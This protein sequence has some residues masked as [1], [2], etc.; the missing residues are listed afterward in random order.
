[1]GI[2]TNMIIVRFTLSII[3]FLPYFSKAQSCD[4][5]FVPPATV[6]GIEVT[7]RDSGSVSIFPAIGGACNLYTVPPGSIYLGR[8]GQ[9]SYEIIFDKAISVLSFVITGTGSAQNETFIFTTNSGN[10]TLIDKGSCKSSINNNVLFSGGGPPF[11]RPGGGE[12]DIINGTPFTRVKI[13]GPGIQNGSIISFCSEVNSVQDTLIKI[14][15]GDSAIIN[16]IYRKKS[17]VY[18]DTIIN[19]SANGSDSIVVYQLR[20]DSIELDLGEDTS[21]CTGESFLLSAGIKNTNASFIWQNS[22]TDSTILINSSGLYWVEI[23]LNGCRNSDSIKVGFN[24][25]P[26]IELGENDTLCKNDTLILNPAT[27]NANYLWQ[28]NSTDSIFIVKETGLYWCEVELNNCKTRDSINIYFEPPSSSFLVDTIL[29]CDGREYLFSISTQYVSYKWQNG[30]AESSFVASDEGLY[31]CEVQSSN[32]IY[33]DSTYLKVI[34]CEVKIDFPN[35]FTPNS[36]GINDFFKPIEVKNI[37]SFNIKICDRWGRSVLESDDENFH[38]DGGGNE[39]GTYF[40]EIMYVDKLGE[41]DKIVGIVK[42]LR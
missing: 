32:C 22:A 10:P 37:S 12:F 35:V 20:V 5:Q 38:W 23:E 25:N 14:C 9:F 24:P 39:S 30:F 17:G 31:W 13:S 16:G 1:M 11:N 42:L 26:I 27:A 8:F 18:L 34:D 6:N 40:W 41:R 33:R 19:G 3:F 28:D 7:S 36:D 4:K 15:K 29:I 21:L 2:S